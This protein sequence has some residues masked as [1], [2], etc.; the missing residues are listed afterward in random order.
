MRNSTLERFLTLGVILAAN[1]VGTGCIGLDDTEEIVLPPY[2]NYGEGEEE[3]PPGSPNL[4]PEARVQ[5]EKDIFVGGETVTLDGS[6]SSDPE[7]DPLTFQGGMTSKISVN[8][9]L[10]QN[11]I[12]DII[13]DQPDS[14]T[15]SFTAPRLASR[16][17][18]N[19]AVTVRDD[20]GNSDVAYAAVTVDAFG[21]VADAGPDQIVTAGDTVSLDATAS[22]HYFDGEITGYLWQQI[23]LPEVLMVDI[24]DAESPVATFEAPDVGENP[25]TMR[26]YLLV[27]GQTN[28]GVRSSNDWMEVEVR[29]EGYIPPPIADAGEDQ[30]NALVGELITL[31]GSGSQ[32][33]SGGQ[34][35]YIWTQT[36][37]ASPRI[38]LDLADPARPTFT[39][40][41]VELRT[42]FRLELEVFD[43]LSQRSDTARALVAVTPLPAALAFAEQ[44]IDDTIAHGQAVETV[45][46]DG[47]GDLD[48]LAAFSLTDAVRLYLN[49]GAG[50]FTMVPISG[51]GAIVAMHVTAGDFNGDGDL[52]VAAVGLFDRAVGFT[53]AGEITWYEN[54]GN[55]AGAWTE[56]Q[57]TGL[58]F[59]GARFIQAGDINGD[60]FDDLIVSAV[61]M[62]DANGAPRGN[63]VYHL[64]NYEGGISFSGPD[65][66]DAA[67]REVETVLIED[68]DGDGVNDVIAAGGNSSEIVWYENLRDAGT[69]EFFPEFQRHTLAVVEEP[70]GLTMANLDADPELELVATVLFRGTN[71][72]IWLDP[73]AD[74]TRPWAT[75]TIMFNLGSADI[76]RATAADFNNDGL[77]DVASVSNPQGDIQMH[78]RQTDGS[79]S[80]QTIAS[81]YAGLTFVAAGNLDAD[82]R[83]DLVLTTYERPG[84]DR[85]SLWR[86]QP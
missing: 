11:E 41:D 72:L 42:I 75:N 85:V 45:D 47:D 29:P 38:Q 84:G 10:S 68:V 51:D 86:N 22:Y 70:L 59:W 79:W 65:P 9:T 78:L 67:L 56:H 13:L 37:P 74:P 32:A 61:E 7:S 50:N 27:D 25:M 23:P 63:G 69:V 55:P 12:P 66:L 34:L 43:D 8:R 18:Y 15:P 24:D 44:I 54:P 57:I 35:N 83:P 52:D 28:D 33:P 49:D 58:T 81:G 73:P 40:P 62:T 36:E 39:A 17:Q 1:L 76:A 21:P 6:E 4:P 31:D 60:P 80:Q 82:N 20:Q 30:H 26:F 16:V 19:F 53:S 64:M 46:I 5:V 2:Y 48:V 3:P 14:A 77:T 71:R